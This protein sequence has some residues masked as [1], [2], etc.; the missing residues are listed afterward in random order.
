MLTVEIEQVAV[1]AALTV[2]LETA[3]AAWTAGA[4]RQNATVE[5]PHIERC[6][7]I[8]VLFMRFLLRQ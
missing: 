2:K 7:A 3:V 8:R 6:F 5:R 4:A 1:T